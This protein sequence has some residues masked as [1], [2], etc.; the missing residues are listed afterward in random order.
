MQATDCQFS[1]SST[2]LSIGQRTVH[3]NKQPQHLPIL[4]VPTT[5]R[6]P[7]LLLLIRVGKFNP[8]RRSRTFSLS[9]LI[10]LILPIEVEHKI[11]NPLFLRLRVIDMFQRRL[12]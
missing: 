4:V 9:P 8:V 2:P 12:R 6:R 11:L 10:L 5:L 7:S 1:T 3:S